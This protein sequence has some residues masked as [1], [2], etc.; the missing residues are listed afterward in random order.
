MPKFLDDLNPIRMVGKV[1]RGGLQSVEGALRDID[2]VVADINREVSP[3]RSAPPAPEDKISDEETLRYQLEAIVDD[4]QHLET[5]HLPAQ[6]RIAGKVCDCISKAA[7]DLRRH[8]RETV[9]IA[10]RQGKDTA[11]Y[12]QVAA[13]AQ[14]MVRIGTADMVA[15]GQFDEEYLRQAGVASTLRKA[16]EGLAAEVRPKGFRESCAEC[17]PVEDLREWLKRKKGEGG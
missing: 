13:W 15:S 1:L 3:E 4:L 16:F 5:E 11:L 14:E 12:S 2:S 10:A 7:R 8:A 6:G 17:G 9:P